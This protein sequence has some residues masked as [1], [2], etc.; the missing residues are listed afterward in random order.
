MSTEIK[1]YFIDNEGNKRDLREISQII[2][3]VIFPPTTPEQAALAK[4][5]LD[6]MDKTTPVFAI[7]V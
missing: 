5:F 2:D 6:S 3:D 4:E 7:D 1:G